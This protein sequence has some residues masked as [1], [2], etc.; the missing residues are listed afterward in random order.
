M[1]PL[2]LTLLLLFSPFALAQADGY[3]GRVPVTDQLPAT[4]TAALGAALGQVLERV[5]GQ[6]GTDPRL[7]GLHGRAPRLL[8]RYSYEKDPAT[9]QLMLLAGFDPRGVDAAVRGL[10]LPVWGQ[11]AVPVEDLTLSVAGLKGIADYVRTLAAVR[12][13]PGVRGVTVL[14]ADGDRIQL[15]ARVEGGAAA[16]AAVPSATLVR[17]SDDAAG[18]SYTLAA[19]TPA[20]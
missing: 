6:L 17:Q 7:Q 8:Q 19:P 5:S 12:A 16:L 9:S 11:V 13:L 1:R 3:L 14:A 15:R 4:R 18:L 2:L 20:Q 10:G